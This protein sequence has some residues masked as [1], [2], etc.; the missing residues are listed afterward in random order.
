MNKLKAEGNY[1]VYSVAYTNCAILIRTCSRVKA[2]MRTWP[3]LAGPCY[4]ALMNCGS[5]A[6]YLRGILSTF[7]PPAGLLAF[8]KIGSRARRGTNGN[9]AGNPAVEARNDAV[10]LSSERFFESFVTPVRYVHYAPRLQIVVA[11]GVL[12]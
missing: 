5:A 6:R 12:F 4:H 7:I 3:P 8:L 11:R 9:D 2:R 1:S 10:K